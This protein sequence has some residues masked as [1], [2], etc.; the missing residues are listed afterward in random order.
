MTEI[1]RRARLFLGSYA[2]LFVLLALRFRSTP[3]EIA[4][5]V[6][7]VIGIAD[8]VWIVFGVSARTAAEPVRVEIVVDAG[9]EV[10]GYLATYLLPFLTV[11]EP[12][13]RDIAAYAIFLLVTGI[14]YVRSEMAQVNPTL[15]LLGR[16]VVHVDTEQGWEGHIVVQSA[17]RPGAVVRTVPLNPMVRVEVRR[18][19]AAA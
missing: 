6:F 1:A 10:A 16:R 14:V 3:L 4:C 2:L 8:M 15:Y 12:T 18:K 13:G 9:P 7:A 17:T 19:A 5:T 11:A